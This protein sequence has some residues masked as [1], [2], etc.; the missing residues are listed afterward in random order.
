MII[1][2]YFPLKRTNFSFFL[3]PIW[4]LYIFLLT[5]INLLSNEQNWYVLNNK[6]KE[7]IIVQREHARNYIN[8]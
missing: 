4:F 1:S 8:L 2:C 7:L 6:S 5:M 3:K